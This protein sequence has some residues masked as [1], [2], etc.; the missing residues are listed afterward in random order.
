MAG[1]YL[2]F[3]NNVYISSCHLVAPSRVGLFA[4]LQYCLFHRLLSR[5]SHDVGVTIMSRSF[6]FIFVKAS[7]SGSSAF[8]RASVI[9]SLGGFPGAISAGMAKIKSILTEDGSVKCH[10]I[11]MCS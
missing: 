9:S 6:L 10:W 2:Y 1:V 8:P 5:L 7:F 4:T 11:I 3:S